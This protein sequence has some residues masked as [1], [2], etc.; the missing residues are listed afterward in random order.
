MNSLSLTTTSPEAA[1]KTQFVCWCAWGD[2]DIVYFDSNNIS[3]GG[4]LGT[5]S[6][7]LLVLQRGSLVLLRV[8]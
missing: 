1:A 4:L 6:L 3:V 5:R 2:F 7:V 8:I